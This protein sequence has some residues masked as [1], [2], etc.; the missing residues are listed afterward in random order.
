MNLHIWVKSPEIRRLGRK[1]KDYA[2][3]LDLNNE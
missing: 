3:Y 1:E 2:D